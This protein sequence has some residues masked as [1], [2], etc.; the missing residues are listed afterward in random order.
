MYVAQVVECSVG[1]DWSL[2]FIHSTTYI[3]NQWLGLV[4]TVLSR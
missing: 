1:I 4:N 2:H 3:R